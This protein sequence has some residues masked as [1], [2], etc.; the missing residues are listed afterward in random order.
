MSNITCGSVVPFY[1]VNFSPGARVVVA[2][3]GE[4]CGG[5]QKEHN[6]TDVTVCHRHRD[7]A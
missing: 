4:M 7:K 6:V 1:C 2:T 5:S 3:G